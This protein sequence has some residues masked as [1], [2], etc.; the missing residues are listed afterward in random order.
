MRAT[1]S[2][3]AST[4]SEARS[5]GREDFDAFYEGD[6]YEVVSESAVPFIVG[7]DGRVKLWEV[8]F[9]AA[10]KGLGA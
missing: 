8:E 2:I 3:H 9:E 10:S 7:E 5:K 4:I 6:K 1:R